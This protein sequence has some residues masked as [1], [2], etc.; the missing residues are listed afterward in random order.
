MDEAV[1][2][3]ETPEAPTAL[4]PEPKKESPER[5]AEMVEKLY[6]AATKMQRDAEALMRAVRDEEPAEEPVEKMTPEE[7][8]AA[9]QAILGL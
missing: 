5:L 7:S 6:E 3:M 4:P 2:P 9:N 8:K 1:L